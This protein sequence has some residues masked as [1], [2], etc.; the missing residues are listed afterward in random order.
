MISAKGL[1]TYCNSI[2]KSNAIYLWGC[3]GEIG[4]KDLI[5]KKKK[6]FGASHYNGKTVDLIEGKLCFDCSGFLTPISGENIT[7][8]SYYDKCVEKG[9][10]SQIPKDKACLIF[11]KQGDKVVHVAVYMGDGN[12]TEMW[13]GCDQ[14][15]FKE[16]EWTYY[17]FPAWLEEQPDKLVVGGTVRITD[18]IKVYNNASNA[19]KGRSELPF[20]YPSGTYYIY[21]I[22]KPTGAVNITKKKGVAGAWIILP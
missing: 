16:S 19:K 9:A 15:K 3:D 10:I 2:H 22:H 13:N 17:G 4:T 5:D 21:K 11:R 7:A 12:L 20:T 6:T 18:A 1:I 14:R 8:Q